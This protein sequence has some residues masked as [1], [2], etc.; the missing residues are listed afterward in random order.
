MQAARNRYISRHAAVIAALRASHNGVTA[1]YFHNQH[2]AILLRAI[3]LTPF[4]A[5]LENGTPCHV[6]GLDPDGMT[7]RLVI[8]RPHDDGGIRADLV[9]IVYGVSLEADDEPEP[10]NG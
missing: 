9:N 6:V 5:K 8:L 10:A 3:P 1:A 4:H 2:R 7:P